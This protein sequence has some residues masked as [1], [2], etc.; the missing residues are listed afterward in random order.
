VDE[1]HGRGRDTV[2][3]RSR[4]GY[5]CLSERCCSV[6]NDGGREY[7]LCIGRRSFTVTYSS[8]PTLIAVGD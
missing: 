6:G 8:A 1:Q 4:S 7:L 5:R 3:H 2:L